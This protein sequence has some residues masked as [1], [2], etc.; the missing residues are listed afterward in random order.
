MAVALGGC[1]TALEQPWLA[2]AGPFL[3]FLAQMGAETIF[4]P[5]VG[6]SILYR[7]VGNF[8]G[9]KF[10]RNRPKFGFQKFSQF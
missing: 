4:F 1:R 2:L 7:M 8:R 5:V 3:T 9:Y 10:S 6:T